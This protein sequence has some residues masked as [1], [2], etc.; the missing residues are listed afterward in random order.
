MSHVVEVVGLDP[1]SKEVIINEVFRWNQHKD[2]FEYSGKSISFD[3]I[4]ELHGISEDQIKDEWHKRKIV[5]E[6]M[7]KND[8]RRYDKVGSI[9][10]EYY[11][12]QE[13]LVKKAKLGLSA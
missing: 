13:K 8:I 7:L 10:R 5:L 12:D 11:T 3:R 2:T 1:V 4:T 9:I 6:W